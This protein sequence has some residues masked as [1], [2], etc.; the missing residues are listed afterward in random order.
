MV[1]AICVGICAMGVFAVLLRL[2]REDKRLAERYTHI[3][4][5]MKRREEL[6]QQREALEEFQ[7]KQE[8][9][10]Q[11]KKASKADMLKEELP[12]DREE[13]PG[14]EPTAPDVGAD[15][16]APETVEEPTAV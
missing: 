4:A 3:K 12:A 1:A 6:E 13:N 11:R 9:E 2:S 7:Q 8:E 15:A 16:A 5:V 14:A 10:E